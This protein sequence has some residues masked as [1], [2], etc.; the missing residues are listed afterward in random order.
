MV[1]YELHVV[2]STV[3]FSTSASSADFA[4]LLIIDGKPTDRLFGALAERYERA[5]GLAL[6]VEEAWLKSLKGQLTNTAAKAT[7][8]H[9]YLLEAR[10]AY[11]FDRIDAAFASMKARAGV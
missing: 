1:A 10:I 11:F 9:R 7:Q 2:S 3:G 5:P 4:K 8:P 6:A